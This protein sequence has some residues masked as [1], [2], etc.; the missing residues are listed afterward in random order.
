[1]S[2][3]TTPTTTKAPS[4]RVRA[5]DFTTLFKEL[6]SVRNNTKPNLQIGS[7]LVVN[8]VLRKYTLRDPIL[9]ALH[10]KCP[11]HAVV[12]ST[13]SAEPTL[14]LHQTPYQTNITEA[15]HAESVRRSYLDSASPN[16]Q[17]QFNQRTMRDTGPGIRLLPV[18]VNPHRVGN[19]P[20]IQLGFL[21]N[22]PTT[23]NVFID[24][25]TMPELMRGLI[26]IIRSRGFQARVKADF[27]TT[28]YLHLNAVATARGLRNVQS[29]LLCPELGATNKLK[30]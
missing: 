17:E 24:T 1:M 27:E 25:K 9:Q 18:P 13:A 7:L 30:G 4:P 11:D 12:L 21:S 20:V 10:T 16:L 14:H 3:P 2:N 19:A 26:R 29:L 28:W 22:N 15:R 23:P 8:S 6:E 5:N